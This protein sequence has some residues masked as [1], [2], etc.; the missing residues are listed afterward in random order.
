MKHDPSHVL[1]ERD[2]LKIFISSTIKECK[3]EREAATKGIRAT[4]N[5]V[6]VFEKL[7]SRPY[8]PRDVYLS[9]LRQAD[10]VVAIYRSNYGYVAPKSQISVSG[11]EDEYRNSVAWG[12]WLLVY[13]HNDRA[14]RDS[15]LQDLIDEISE[16]GNTIAFYDNPD[17][18]FTRI[19][20]DVTALITQRFLDAEAQDIAL[21][22]T[23]A[24]TIQAVSHG[25]GEP[26]PRNSVLNK[27]N[28]LA[29]K[30]SVVCVEGPPGI[31]KTVLVSQFA[32]R[33]A[34]PIVFAES[35]APKELFG[36]VT[37][38]LRDRSPETALQFAT[39]EGAR[40][41]L[42]SAWADIESCSIIIDASPHIEVVISAI[43]QAGGFTAKKRLI[44]T[45]RLQPTSTDVAFQVPAMSLEDVSALISSAGAQRR[46]NNPKDVLMS[47]EGVPLR[48]RQLILSNNIN[49][50]QVW[51]ALPPTAREIATY[52][53]LSPISLTI[54]DLLT[55]RG[56]SG[57]GPEHV[58]DDLDRMPALIIST[59]SGYRPAHQQIKEELL[60]TIK[61]KPERLQFAASRVGAYLQGKGRIV[62]AYLLFRDAK[63]PKSKSLIEQAAYEAA[64][65]GNKRAS[66]EILQDL[67]TLRAELGQRDELVHCT[68]ALAQTYE[69][70]GD[71]TS[72]K[73]YLA[74]AQE[75]AK[76]LSSGIV[77]AV[78]EAELSFEAR[79][80]HL[81]NAITQLRKFKKELADA[82]NRWTSAR[83]AIDISVSLI[84]SHDG[85]GAEKEAREALQIFEELDDSYGVD[86]ARRNLASA[87]VYQS[88]R[89]K[90]VDEIIQVLD[91]HS[92]PQEARRHRA[93]LC[94]ILVRRK[95]DANRP[96]EAITYAN[97]AVALGKELGDEII[98]AI[99]L[100][101]LANA[102]SD[103]NDL[104]SAITKYQE[105]SSTAQKLGR[106]DIEAHASVLIADTYN[107]L[108]EEHA[109]YNKGPQLA[110]FHAKHAIGLLKGTIG[111]DHLGRAFQA[112]G[113]SLQAQERP[114]EAAAAYFEGASAAREIKKWGR[115][116][117]LLMTAVHLTARVDIRDYYEG[118]LVAFGIEPETLSLGSSIVSQFHAP[119]AIILERLPQNAV[120]PFLGVHFN[121]MFEGLPPPVGRHVFEKVFE[122]IFDGDNNAEAQ[123]W[124]VVYPT[125][126]LL[127][128]AGRS[129]TPFDLSRISLS[130]AEQVPGLSFRLTP[131]GTGYWYVQ[132]PYKTPVMITL[133]QLDE[134]KHSALA[135]LVIALFLKGF[136]IELGRDVFGGISLRSELEIS[137]TDVASMP[138][139]LKQYVPTGDKPCQSSRPVSIDH[140]DPSMP[141]YIFLNGD[142]F[143]DMPV[144]KGRGGSLQILIG[145]ATIE[146]AYRLLNGKID[147]DVLKPKLVHL[148]RNSIS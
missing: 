51:N 70:T 113:D 28:E 48:I 88:G 21:R 87:L 20:D 130:I 95:R 27:L 100:I 79:R 122:T 136:E 96:Q 121:L 19:R 40:L 32:Q 138:A 3:N 31:G 52:I 58:V 49:S 89:D 72:A 74:A 39:L 92:D 5:D 56:D 22:Q 12:K 61:L 76:N 116:E 137:I 83:V 86:V 102:F 114:V 81:P 119:L 109:D 127:A 139:D 141:T 106:R 135:L 117:Q 29:N 101:G 67:L 104:D 128:A 82:G 38:K 42:A 17:E 63:D 123:T 41:A 8:P 2:K 59:G 131:D 91:K 124:R 62:Q 118:I 107:D 60:E 146:A 78:R 129:L 125:L 15:K 133:S 34:W 54:E 1:A 11:L 108:P 33:Y 71:L 75:A 65:S 140:D 10:I 145:L 126:I 64:R 103:I 112:L 44:F 69:H 66:L 14:S 80:T 9:R 30:S 26:I 18:L 7:G 46:L 37:N 25:I 35:L 90:E 94:N 55:L 77:L 43:E 16:S 115:F 99:N 111:Q 148:V 4:N 144:G 36:T 120:I 68:L 97:E 110:E 134:T 93:W 50:E 6:I 47:T 98:V 147:L 143:A 24:D 132:L 23:S 142:I 45:S 73:K 13:V 57:Y 53:A 84:N 105:A 85:A